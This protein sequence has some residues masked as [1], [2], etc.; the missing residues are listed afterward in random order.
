MMECLDEVIKAWPHLREL[1]LLY[2]PVPAGLP[3][4]ALSALVEHCPRLQTLWL[5]SVDLRG[6]KKRSLDLC[7]KA[8]NHAL[9]Q[10]WLAGDAPK[11]DGR[12]IAEFVDKMFPHVD[13]RPVDYPW[14]SSRSSNTWKG[15]LASLK[16]VKAA[17]VSSSPVV[18][19]EE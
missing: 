15:V 16:E 11:A 17:R 9:R 14:Q 5:A 7:P 13:L 1:R 3:I 19:M 6:V 10:I 12:R 4:D 18:E 8:S 2:Q